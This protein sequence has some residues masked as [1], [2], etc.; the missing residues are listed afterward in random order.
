M[1]RRR[2]GVESITGKLAKTVLNS[3]PLSVQIHLNRY[4]ELSQWKPDI[5]SRKI[6]KTCSSIGLDWASCHTLRFTFA[7]HLAMAGVSLYTAKELLGHS[8]IKTT[9]IYAHLADSHKSE[10]ISRLPY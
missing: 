2:F 10:M 5:V 7:S 1:S 3:N 9:E 6:S 4:N 8:S